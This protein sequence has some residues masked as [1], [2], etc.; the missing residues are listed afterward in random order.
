[1]DKMVLIKEFCERIVVGMFDCKK[2]LEVLNWDVEEVI[3]FLKK[4]GKIK[5]VLKVNRILVDGFL[6]EVGNNER[7]VLV[8]LN[9]EIDFVVYGEEFVVLVNIVV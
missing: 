4:N 8:E 2:V 6:V 5:V 7:V 9:C 1:M 3:L